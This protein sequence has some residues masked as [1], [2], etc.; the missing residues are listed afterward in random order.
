MTRTLM[1]LVVALL[2]VAPLAAQAPKPK[3]KPT[4]PSAADLFG[5]RP[6]LERRAPRPVDAEDD[7]WEDEHDGRQ[8]PP[9][10][11]PGWCRGRGNPHNTPEN[12][13][14]EGR[15]RRGDRFDRRQRWDGYDSFEEA[16]R[17]FHRELHAWCAARRTEHPLDL[18]W[19][20][21]VRQECA[22][23]HA[24]WHRRYDPRHRRAR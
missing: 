22:R 6:T 3:T 19:Q 23:R 14:P 7:E 4:S 1:L 20:L 13:G 8:G 2:G 16:H 18:E 11:P 10:V 17:A 9:F 12:C 5:E 15:R 21:Q 24:E